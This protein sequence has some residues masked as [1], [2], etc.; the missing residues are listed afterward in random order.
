M[1]A[2]DPRHPSDRKLAYELFHPLVAE[3]FCGRFGEPTEPQKDGW[4]AIAKRQNTL[5]SAPTGSGKTLAAFLWCLN[6]LVVSALKGKLR[7]NTSTIYVSPL[8]ALGNDVCRN[9]ED[10]LAEIRE[11]AEKKGTALPPIRVATRSGDTP[12]SVRAKMVKQ[13]PHILI[14]TPETLYILLTSDSGR[15]NL[16]FADTIIVD[17][18]HAIAGD[19]RG[20]HLA[21]SL[22]RL[23]RLVTQANNKPPVRIGLSATQNPIERIGR[24]L[25]GNKNPLP[26]I[27]DGGHARTIDIAIE[28]TGDELGPLASNEQCSRMYDRIA[29]LVSEHKTT[30][31][32]ANTRRLVERA[33]HNLEERLGEE[34]VVAH[35]GSLSRQT[36]LDSEQKLKTG[37]VK[38]AVATASLELGIDV[39]AV[40]L[41]VQIGSPRSIS[42]LL[43]RIG[44]SGH[45]LGKTPKGRLF[46]LTR[47]QLVECVALARAI[48][49]K[50]LDEVFLVEAPLDVLS[51][52][53]VA[54]VSA[55]EA[56]PDDLFA[57]VTNAAHYASLKREEFDSVLTILSEGASPNLGR[58]TAQLHWDRLENKLRA[59]RGARLAALTNGG[60]IPDTATYPVVTFPEETPVG[61]LDE[62]FA[63]ESHPGDVF[64][65][66]NTSWRIRRVQAGRVLVE[67]AAG[68]PPTI[69]FWFGEA[70]ARTHELSEEICTLR[71]DIAARLK[72]STGTSAAVTWLESEIATSP[73][74]A[75][76]TVD[77]IASAISELGA[78][79]T[80]EHL[81]AERFFDN[82]G[83]MQLVI[84]SPLGARVNK[85]W[86]LALRKRFCRSFNLELQ[87]A[88]TDDGILLSLGPVHSFALED[89]FGY[90]PSKK[91]RKILSQAVL[92]APV[93]GVRWRWSVT[94][95]LAVLRR[96]GGKKVPP[97]ILRMRTDDLLSLVFPMQQACLEN[98]V[99]DIDIP[100]HPLVFETMR[101]CLTEFMDIDG[102]THLIEGIESGSV[103]WSTRDTTQASQFSHE[104]I[105]AN[106]YAFLDEVP[107]E[108]RRTRAVSL[109]RGIRNSTPHTED[110]TISE[111]AVK[112]VEAQAFPPIRDPDELHDALLTF[113]LF[114]ER[115]GNT[116]TFFQKLAD[117][118]R[119]TCLSYEYQ[120]RIFRAWVAAERLP[121]V[122]HAIPGALPNPELP[123]LCQDLT[124]GLPND[125][126]EAT[127]QIVQGHMEHLGP[128]AALEL[129]NELGIPDNQVEASMLALE[130]R[131]SLLRRTDD[132]TLRFCNRRILAR[133]HRSTL[134]T[135]RKQIE[136]VSAATLMRFLFRW[137]R[138]TPESKLLGDAGLLEVIEQLQGFESASGAWEQAVL[139]QRLFDYS[140]AWLDR[141]CYE[142]HVSWARLNAK[143]FSEN[144]KSTPGRS[145]PLAFFLREDAHWV[146]ATAEPSCPEELP[147]KAALIY[148]Q[149]ENQGAS[150]LTDLCAATSLSPLDA[151]EGLWS[152]V[153]AG[154]ATAD[155]FTCLRVLVDKHKGQNRSVFDIGRPAP[156]RNS[157]WQK[158]I[159]K[160]RHRDTQRTTTSFKSL[161]SGSGRWSLLPDST[162]SNPSAAGWGEQLLRRYGVVFREL[163]TRE[164]AAPPWRELLATFRRLEAR[165]EVRGGRF[166]SG[167]VGEQFATPDA[168]QQ[169]RALRYMHASKT[170]L[171]RI[172]ATDPLNLVGI[173]S[174][175]SK[176][177]AVLGNE[178]LYRNGVPIAAREGGKC[179]LRAE[180][181]PGEQVNAEL[182]YTRKPSPVNQPQAALPL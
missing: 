34:S 47:D 28:D 9:L 15:A 136:P 166:I 128:R 64:L 141:L 87:A 41:V 57:M 12:A 134:A 138:A 71:K 73:N 164:T 66:G 109:P 14:T 177:P 113:W 78:V 111:E 147:R 133:I 35:H 22:E 121:G 156:R 16:A 25:V 83:G 105:S 180:I 152:L 72:A 137:Q 30:L 140:P 123:P 161:P 50:R 148:R 119:A 130:S 18:I 85:A 23:D 4:P 172:S 37:Q 69:P 98:V 175:G 99:G 60:A 10:P 86:G 142:G 153:T 118:N 81:I 162:E 63:I 110:A 151:E 61:S 159:K 36:R 84:H 97:H 49:S 26:K 157:R 154:L 79:P 21:L 104:L 139:P 182:R 82:A 173:T 5:I 149:L 48:K 117:R 65:L 91:A 74:Y 7:N 94:R 145:A 56:S 115:T 106:P 89:I 53:L 155:G 124:N 42:V 6:R 32:F 92:G 1:S 169:L 126:E 100:D 70:P 174:P 27:V 168:L 40:D 181:E 112:T 17:E 43:Q 51:Q 55:E 129:A 2:Q 176:V 76:Q 80:S 102:L 29:E 179:V 103:T 114:P 108:E 20:A 39:G 107:A 59:R 19:K 95:A 3:W 146:L 158:T 75:K 120:G 33:A 131:G 116:A 77:Y 68:L 125:I 44:R 170:E 135:L 150:F 171:V 93:F 54:T 31:V 90:L 11:L 167:F 163:L 88:A 178:I 122:L 46:A 67:D 101:D 165:G 144:S 127:L 132:D 160:S 45:S 143:T 96:Y 62:E 52:Q 58:K 38:C 24:L 13:P 8:K